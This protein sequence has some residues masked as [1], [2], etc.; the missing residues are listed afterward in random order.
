MPIRDVGPPAF[1]P[2]EVLVTMILGG[3]PDDLLPLLLVLSYL[4]LGFPQI[5]LMQ[6]NDPHSTS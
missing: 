1:D 3:P 2:D 5:L 6:L 4:A